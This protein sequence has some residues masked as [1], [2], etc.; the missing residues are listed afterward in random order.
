MMSKQTGKDH[1]A[2]RWP[3]ARLALGS[4]EQQ[5]AVV[6]E[7]RHPAW[8]EVV[9]FDLDGHSRELRVAVGSSVF[10]PTVIYD[11]EH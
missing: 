3:C 11:V 5:T 1:H 8:D 7:T 9:P 4:T 2:K 10:G 6:P